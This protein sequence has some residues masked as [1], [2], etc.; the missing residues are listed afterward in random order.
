MTTMKKHRSSYTT[1]EVVVQEEGDDL[2]LPIPPQ[3][4]ESLGWKEGDEIDISLDD[5]GR[6]VIKKVK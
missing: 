6:Y 5:Q 1:Y 2:L 4:L 3:L